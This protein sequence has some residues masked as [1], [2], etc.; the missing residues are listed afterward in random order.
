M[1]FGIIVTKLQGGAAYTTMQALPRGTV[2]GV[3]MVWFDAFVI[4]DEIHQSIGRV[5][6]D[7]HSTAEIVHEKTIG[8]PLAGITPS[9]E[10]VVHYLEV[11]LYVFDEIVNLAGA[12]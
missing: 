1:L 9:L 5:C 8:V 3:E 4:T 7:G 6:G 10:S 11:T 2:V 12:I